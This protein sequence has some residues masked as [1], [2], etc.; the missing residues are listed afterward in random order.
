MVELFASKLKR[1]FLIN[2]LQKYPSR[3]MVGIWNK[4]RNRELSYHN[5]SRKTIIPVLVR[6]IIH[7]GRKTGK[8][9]S[10]PE[11]LIKASEFC[12]IVVKP[13]E[14]PKSSR[15][16]DR[17]PFITSKSGANTFITSATTGF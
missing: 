10:L 15:A 5:W 4:D 8:S 2:V 12:F 3:K 14:S 11:N 7:S 6:T 13:R 16:P 9:L 17:K 1:K